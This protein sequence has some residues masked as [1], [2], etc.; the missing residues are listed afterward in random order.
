MA[1][2]YTTMPTIVE[3]IDTFIKPHYKKILIVVALIV[4]SVA[5]YYIYNKWNKP[6]ADKYKDIYQ[7][8]DDG[9]N[10]ATV[11]FFFA[12]WC[13][14]C[15]KAKPEWTVFANEKDGKIVNG[16]KLRCIM[17]DCSDPDV[18]DVAAKIDQYE[19]KS[20]PTIKLVFKDNTY[21]F[22]ASVTKEHLDQFVETIIV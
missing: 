22:D 12:D 3:V 17:V 9:S 4:F 8:N 19:I 20:Y 13:P 16:T 7:P 1:S 18:P 15:T 10:E 21:D 11:Y 2:F 6:V 5:A 14:H